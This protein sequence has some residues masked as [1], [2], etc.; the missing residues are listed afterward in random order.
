M[1]LLLGSRG[2]FVLSRIDAY[3]QGQGLQRS[4]QTK[5]KTL[6]QV[7]EAFNDNTGEEEQQV[8]QMLADQGRLRT[9]GESPVK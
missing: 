7:D 9:N 6:E 2:K 5:G 4:I 1:G 3:T 8:M